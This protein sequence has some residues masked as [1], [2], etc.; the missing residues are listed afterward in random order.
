MTSQDTPP[1]SRLPV[2]VWAATAP[3]RSHPERNED[4]YWSAENGVV[5]A[6]IDGMGGSRRLVPGL[7][8]VG[9]EHAAQGI[10]RVLD[11]RLQGVS[12]DITVEEARETLR[13]V[14]S[15]AAVRVF[16]E[17]N[18]EGA[19]PPEQVPEGSS[20]LDVM[21]AACA[22]VTVLCERGA[23]AVIAQHGD[24]RAYLVSGGELLPLTED[25]DAVGRDVETGTL[26]HEAGLAISAELDAFDGRTLGDLSPQALRY[27]SIRNLVYGQLGDS[28]PAPEPSL[29]VIRL[30]PADAL[31][32]TSDGVHDNL[33]AAEIA[34]L[35]GQPDP[36]A[37]LVTTAD[38]RSTESPLPHPGDPTAPYNYRAHPDDATAIVVK[39]E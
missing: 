23:R 6:V 25:Q 2:R 8:E 16:R 30:S 9:G 34:A 24:T 5:H 36:A 29:L 7:G 17:V 22:T 12:P 10:V 32:L 13:R 18:A 39:Q 1:V 4:A 33:S 21:A 35:L 28:D 3:S 31:L 19:I 11:E 26:P 15:E 38:R 27:Y 14:L 20:A 37:A